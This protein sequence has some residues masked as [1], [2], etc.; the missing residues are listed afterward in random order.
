MTQLHQLLS[1]N[2]NSPSKQ[3]H[4]NSSENQRYACS[5]ITHK[6]PINNNS[7]IY[8][9]ISYRRQYRTVHTKRNQTI[10]KKICTAERIRMSYIEQQLHQS[11][12]QHKIALQL[13]IAVARQA[14]N[15]FALQWMWQNISREQRSNNNNKKFFAAYIITFTYRNLCIEMH[16]D[17]L[18]YR[19]KL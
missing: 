12:Q 19:S 17:P 15:N 14:V 3:E 13:L 9:F 5:L 7:N 10:S 16:V 8:H 2:S 1:I 4:V 6:R 18:I 11:Q